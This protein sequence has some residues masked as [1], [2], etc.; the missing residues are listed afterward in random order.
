MGSSVA[1]SSAWRLMCCKRFI[2]VKADLIFS[3]FARSLA[4]TRALRIQFVG[5]LPR[6]YSSL[7]TFLCI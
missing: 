2:G 5:I 6:K 1:I 7:E 4:V 3:F